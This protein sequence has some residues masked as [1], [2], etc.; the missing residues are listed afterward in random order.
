MQQCIGATRP[1]AGRARPRGRRRRCFVGGSEPGAMATGRQPRSTTKQPGLPTKHEAVD[2][3]AGRS[4]MEA[5]ATP[6]AAPPLMFGAPAPPGELLPWSWAHQRLETA[7]T[8]WIATTRPYGRPHCRPVW[9]VWLADGFWFS[10]G[11]LARHNLATNPQI[12]VHLDSGTE[13]V[14]VEGVA[15]AVAGGRP[16]AGV[17]SRLQHQVQLGHLRHRRRRRRLV[18]GRR[19]GL[20]GAAAGRFRLGHRPAHRDPVVV[21]RLHHGHH[22]VGGPADLADRSQGRSARQRRFGRC[23]ADDVHEAVGRDLVSIVVSRGLLS[24]RGPRRAA[25]AGARARRECRS[26]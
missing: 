10:T 21:R 15:A 25:R 8:Y 4:N 3:H 23:P 5:I 7:H 14:I 6:T 1:L 24:R 19:A 16:A 17:P 20:P 26:R 18:R 22:P 2:H 13:V 9:G 12:T 11:S